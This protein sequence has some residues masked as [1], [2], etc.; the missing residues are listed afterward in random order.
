M[1]SHPTSPSPS[2][3]WICTLHCPLVNKVRPF[4]HTSYLKNVLW[5]LSAL[6]VPLFRSTEFVIFSAGLARYPSFIS[7]RSFLM[8]PAEFPHGQA[9]SL[10]SI[11]LC[12]LSP[13]LFLMPHR[14]DP[15]LKGG[16]QGRGTTF[17]PCSLS[18][19]EAFNL[20][21]LATKSTAYF[22]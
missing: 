16:R 3:V 4:S 17:L 2:E 21:V 9:G 18:L 15:S 7:A 12:N 6:M 10:S 20:P 8:T 11:F 19:R 22:S 13:F 1:L 5:N 14:P